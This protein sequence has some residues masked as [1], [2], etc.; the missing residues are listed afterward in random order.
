MNKKVT[1]I[2]YIHDDDSRDNKTLEND[3]TEEMNDLI[4]EADIDDGTVHSVTVED[5]I[6]LAR[7]ESDGDKF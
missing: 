5:Y 6:P 3:F 7:I 4:M 1:I 2:L